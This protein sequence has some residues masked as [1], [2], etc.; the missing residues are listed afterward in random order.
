MRGLEREEGGDQA[1]Q[2]VTVWLM[3]A[4][5][6]HVFMALNYERSGVHDR[7]SAESHP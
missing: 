6:H 4:A 2:V 5:V 3:P 1:V 7:L